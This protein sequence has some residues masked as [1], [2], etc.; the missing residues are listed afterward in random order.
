MGEIG[1]W[2]PAL[3]TRFRAAKG[4][5]RRHLLEQLL[6][7]NTPLIKLLLE[8]LRGGKNSGRKGMKV[9]GGCQG[10]DELDW[11]DAMQAS[12]I[13]FVKAAEAFDPAKGKIAGYL[14]L[15]MRHELQTLV[16]NELRL[17]RVPRGRESELIP[18][19]L[20]GEQ[21]ELDRMGGSVED[22]LADVE[23]ITAEDVERWGASGEW[24]ETLEEARVQTSARRASA[25]PEQPADP[26]SAL[27]RF[28]EEELVRRANARVPKSL[29][30]S[31]YEQFCVS[32]SQQPVSREEL[33]DSLE[34]TGLTETRMRWRGRPIRALAGA[35]LKKGVTTK[36][37][38]G[39]HAAPVRADKQHDY[40]KWYG[41]LLQ[42]WVRKGSPMLAA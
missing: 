26:R 1:K 11:D 9:L 5:R 41:N 28:L 22:G 27:E 24:P 23:G 35:T 6:V 8:Q 33:Y 16:T 29:V 31:T 18:V 19:A 7:E 40:E 14:K 12:R 39:T 34:S 20:V 2:D 30:A 17:A 13:A 37:S 15:K 32:L 25:E 10:I 3:F 38:A 4:I 42:T 36:V 21:Q